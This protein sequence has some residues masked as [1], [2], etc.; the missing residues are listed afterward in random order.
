MIEALDKMAQPD[1]QQAQMQQMAVQMDMEQKR[2]T[3]ESLKARAM[4]DGAEA[5][6]TMVEAQLAPEEV[7]AKI[8]KNK[9]APPMKVVE[10]DII[11]AKGI[12]EYGC[13]FDVGLDKGIFSQKGAWIYLNG[14]FG[15]LANRKMIANL[16]HQL[17]KVLRQ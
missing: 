9:M 10:F 2:A 11:Y 6:K 3:T 17:L 7:K 8:I 14:D 15:I 1:P 4:R 13:L 16:A 5:Q 12:D